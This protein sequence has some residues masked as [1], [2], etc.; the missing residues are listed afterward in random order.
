M[1]EMQTMVAACAALGVF[2]FLIWKFA[3]GSAPE[4]GRDSALVCW[5]LY[6]LLSLPRIIFFVAVVVIA[7]AAFKYLRS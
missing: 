5:T 4:E 3:F 6:G 1:S 2:L 7:L